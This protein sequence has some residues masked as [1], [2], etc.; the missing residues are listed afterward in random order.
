MLYDPPGRK[1]LAD[2]QQAGVEVV[3]L[4]PVYLAAR[5]ED[6]SAGAFLYQKHDTHWN[7][8]G[9]ELAADSIA[10]RIRSYAWY[11]RSSDTVAYTFRDT[12]I[13][14]TGDLA[15]RLPPERQPAY[16]PQSLAVR[17]VFNPD[18][19][20]YCGNHIGAP[21]LLVGDSF[22][23]VF[24]LVDCKSAGIGS[25]LAARCRLPVDNITSWGGGPMVQGKMLRARGKYLDRKRVVVYLMVAR[26]LYD[27]SQGWEP[28]LG[29]E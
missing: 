10:A 28:L 15:D 5:A 11:R 13:V 18:G 17:R 27:Y 14:R 2:L 16:K 26:D 25:H 20:P 22:T 6:S 21:I 24:E 7:G 29:G 19:T 3:D 12:E 1:F 4:L 23:G 9:M 8:R